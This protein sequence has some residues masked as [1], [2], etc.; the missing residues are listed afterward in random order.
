MVAVVAVEPVDRWVLARLAEKTISTEWVAAVEAAMAAAPRV[1]LHRQQVQVQPVAMM[2]LDPAAERQV[3]KPPWVAMA[4]MVA[5]VEAEDPTSLQQAL[6]KPAVL[7]VRALTS[8]QLTTSAVGAEAEEEALLTMEPSESAE[9]E[10]ATAAVV[11][12]AEP[13]CQETSTAAPA[14]RA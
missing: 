2:R 1:L 6:E 12:G 11:A 9:L 14:P 7:A 8:M 3:R 4:P 13:T 5:A 10:E